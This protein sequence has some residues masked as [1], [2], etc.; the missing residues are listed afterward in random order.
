MVLCFSESERTSHSKR[1]SPNHTGVPSGTRPL[2][3]SLAQEGSTGEPLGRELPLAVL[4]AS[5]QSS[6]KASQGTQF[7]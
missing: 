6:G 2:P 3:I 4:G 7:N 1:L 5:A